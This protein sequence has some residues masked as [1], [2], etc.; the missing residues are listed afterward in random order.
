M[1]ANGECVSMRR[2][3]NNAPKPMSQYSD[4]D[5]YLRIATRR[6]GNGVYTPVHHAV[7]MAWVGPKPDG[8]QARHLDGNKR[9]NS[10]GNLCWGTCRENLADRFKHGTITRGERNGCARMNES[11]VMSLR[12]QHIDKPWSV[13]VKE[14][15]QYSKFAI[16]AAIT[17]YSW[18][19][20]PGAI[21]GGRK[22]TKQG[23][24]NGEKLR[25]I[26]TKTVSD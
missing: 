25:E 10:V 14:N 8:M 13:L 9:N 4:T 11:I 15:P 16:W 5:G 3:N 7:L 2:R 21:P 24:R 19:H 6:A 1:S 17:G 18:A 26:Q 12:K 20:L 23:W 22:C